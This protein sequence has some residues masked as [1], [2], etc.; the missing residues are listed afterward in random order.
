MLTNT[1]PASLTLNRNE[2]HEEAPPVSQL[3]F[4]QLVHA[5]NEALEL[6]VQN[7]LV[8]ADNDMGE[9]L[10]LIEQFAQAPFV[11]PWEA[12]VVGDGDLPMVQYVD[13]ITGEV[14]TEHPGLDVLLQLIREHEHRHRS[15]PLRRSR[16]SLQC[17]SRRLPTSTPLPTRPSTSNSRTRTTT[18]ALPL[19]TELEFTSW[20]KELSIEGAPVTHQ[21]VLIHDLQ[22]GFFRVRIDDSSLELEVDKLDGKYGIVEPVD[23]FVGA[24]VTLFGK[25]V[26]LM[27]ASSAT[28]RWIETQAEKFNKIIRQ[29]RE[30]LH[31]FGIEPVSVPYRPRLEGRGPGSTNLRLLKR[32]IDILQ[33]QLA[34]ATGSPSRLL[35]LAG[36]KQAFFLTT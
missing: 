22:T 23:L 1:R 5:V 7:L 2:E 6:D 19:A 29:L 16:S 13:T 24:T 17:S 12:R 10:Q 26:T 9:V 34:A 35:P 32:E 28:V 15:T 11:P 3:V 33:G 30:Q 18:A 4:E 27:R 21:L 31:V 14:S 25:K 8:E 36:E 20:W